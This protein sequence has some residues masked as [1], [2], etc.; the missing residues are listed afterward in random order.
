[1][2]GSSDYR[3]FIPDIDENQG[4]LTGEALLEVNR[5]IEMN[6][7]AIQG[8]N[9]AINN[10]DDANIRQY[11]EEI[12]TFHELQ[13]RKLGET[14]IQYGAVPESR[15]TIAGVLHRGW[16]KVKTAIAENN[17]EVLLE[18]CVFGE[19]ELDAAFEKALSKPFMEDPLHEV[20]A[21]LHEGQFE[22]RQR[23]EEFAK[24]YRKA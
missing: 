22:N 13:N 15:G 24:T 2:T 1:M 21:K 19:K 16:M 14:V 10:V 5:L 11:F 17:V 7:N 12:K 3:Y 6:L 23:L 4:K 18:A 8:Y 9:V 20:V